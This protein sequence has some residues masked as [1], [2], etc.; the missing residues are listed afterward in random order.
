MRNLPIRKNC[1]VWK[2][3]GKHPNGVKS[4]GIFIKPLNKKKEE[5]N[6]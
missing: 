5:K 4:F 1:I 2:V 6:K 3:W